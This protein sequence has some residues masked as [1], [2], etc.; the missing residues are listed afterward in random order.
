MANFLS[1]G[2]RSAKP[3]IVVMIPDSFLQI[4]VTPYFFSVNFFLR[5]SLIRVPGPSLFPLR[6]VEIIVLLYLIGILL[7]Y[8]IC[9]FKVHNVMI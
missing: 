1:M 7:T 9:K 3:S 5:F 2:G 8:N 6:F 4:P